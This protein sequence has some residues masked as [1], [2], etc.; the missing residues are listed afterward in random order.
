MNFVSDTFTDTSGT[1]LEDH[2]GEV[3]AT[4]TEH[5]SYT[6]GV[7]KISDANRLRGNTGI[8]AHYASGS[9]ATA[10]YD[11]TADLIQRSAMA[12]GYSGICGRM[13]T[14]EN[15]MYRGGYQTTSTK[16]TLAK[17]VTGTT[18]ELGSYTQSL[19]NDQAY[20]LKLEIRD[21]AKK[22]Y[23]D[24]VERIS[25]G[26][27]AITAANSAGARCT[28]GSDTTGYH[29]DNL[30]ATD[31]GGGTTIDAEAADG[32]AAGDSSSRIA[33]LQAAAA[34]G[35]AVGDAGGNLAALLASAAD[36]AIS[37]DAVAALA[38][39]LTS[40]ADGTLLADL[41]TRRAD[42]LAAAA[43]GAAFGDAIPEGIVSLL[44]SAADGIALSDAALARADLQVG[45]SDGARLSEALSAL[46]SL[47]ASAGDGV[48]LGD[49]SAA[50]LLGIIVEAL[51]ADGIALS[52]SAA[53]ALLILAQAADGATF[54]DDGAARLSLTA[55][56]ADGAR[57]SETL[58]AVM[59]LAAACADG[60]TVSDASAWPASA[61]GAV[62]I[63][64]AAR[65][66]T[67]SF[68]VRRPGITFTA[69]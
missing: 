49:G 42:L 40:A 59:A 65:R 64:F 19:T 30:V 12:S 29:L 53:R 52:D 25:S 61:S 56:C 16:W 35:L 6:S 14:A 22:L 21:A 9:P 7:Q 13:A 11:V 20:A 38:S 63:T 33:V 68:T 60:F 43:D 28:G 3:G 39:L 23:V 26:D 55:T 47:L 36:G 32:I 8:A 34:D 58:A 37:S 10:E 66:A 69:H 48:S 1:N 2:T 50:S 27:N 4:W 18:T 46:A 51:A 54:S 57:F 31:A 44:V 67:I 17:I 62:T 5:P 41:A 45:A 24:S 15:T